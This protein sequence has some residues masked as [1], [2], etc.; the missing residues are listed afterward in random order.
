MVIFS[1]ILVIPECSYRGYGLYTIFPMNPSGMT[2]C[3]R[4]ANLRGDLMTRPYF[5]ASILSVV[6]LLSTGACTKTEKP[7]PV[8]GNPAPSFTLTDIDGKKVNLPDLSGKV[9]ILDFWA[10]WCAPCKA[11]TRELQKL[12][13]KYQSR[14]VI[15]LGISMD[16]GKSAVE[17]VREFAG[18]NGLTYTMLMDDGRMSKT[19][20]VRNIPAAFIL[21]QQQK[22]VKIYP[23]YLPDFGTMI[24]KELDGLLKG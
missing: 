17:Q 23:G 4:Y 10:T 19:Y 20:A 2:E 9:V 24:E 22:I 8:V 14:G 16:T 13:E 12:H 18:K 3:E 15:V 6:L 21:D 11:S 5:A 1:Q 7:L